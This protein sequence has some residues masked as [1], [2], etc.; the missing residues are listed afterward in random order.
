VRLTGAGE[1]P[2]LIVEGPTGVWF[3]TPEA[4]R[5]GNAVDYAVPVELDPGATLKDAEVTLT[6]AGSA[7]AIE[8]KRKLD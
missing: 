1:T 5:D 8:A 6:F 2:S 4:A 7:T 3:G